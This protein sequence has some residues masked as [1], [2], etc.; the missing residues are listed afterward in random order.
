MLY[1]LAAD[2][3]V[4]FHLCFILF[5]ALGGLVVLWRPVAAFAHIPAAAWG[6]IVELGHFRCPLTRFELSLHRAGGSRGYTD[7][8]IHHYLVRVIYPAGLTDGMQIAIGLTFLILNLTAYSL[9]VYLLY[10]RAWTRR[11]VASGGGF[12]VKF[13]SAHTDESRADESDARPAYPG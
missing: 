1:R 11:S 5:A 6:V 3:V 8:F 13:R 9:V 7:D 12:P 2:G 10:R 4:V